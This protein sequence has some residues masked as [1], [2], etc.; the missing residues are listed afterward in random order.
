MR[1]VAISHSFQ[2]KIDKLCDTFLQ[3]SKCRAQFAFFFYIP[4]FRLCGFIIAESRD[5][6]W[7]SQSIVK[8]IQINT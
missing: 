3:K 5:F 8:I 4:R 6:F 2:W 1:V 7:I